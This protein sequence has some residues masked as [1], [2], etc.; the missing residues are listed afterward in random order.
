MP[1]CAHHVTDPSL[2][3]CSKVKQVSTSCTKQ[4]SNSGYKTKYGDDKK[5]SQSNYSLSGANEIKNDI[6]NYGPVTAA[7]SV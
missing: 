3:D 1:K 5:K 6:L 7:F 2:Q 4:C